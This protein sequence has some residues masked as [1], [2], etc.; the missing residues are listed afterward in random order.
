MGNVYLRKGVGHNRESLEQSYYLGSGL[1]KWTLE[2]TLKELHKI[3]TNWIK[4]VW[5]EI[6]TI[7]WKSEI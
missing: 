4:N 1:K 6:K 2:V 5:V 3:K 7:F